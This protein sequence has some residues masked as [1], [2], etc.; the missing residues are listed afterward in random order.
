VNST[1]IDMHGATIKEMVINSFST[2]YG[3]C[4]DSASKW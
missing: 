4:F 1:Y 3:K 2:R